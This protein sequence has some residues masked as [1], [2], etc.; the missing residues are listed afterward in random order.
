MFIYPEIYLYHSK[1]NLMNSLIRVLKDYRNYLEKHNLAKG[2]N[3]PY[4]VGWVDRF[5]RFAKPLQSHKF[6]TV[7]EMFRS[8]L[9]KTDIRPWQLRQAIDA[10]S[11]Y[12]Y[13]FR[14]SLPDYV[15]G[16][17]CKMSDKEICDL[18]EQFAA[19]KRYS[20]ATK[21]SYLH[22]IRRFLGWR[23]KMDIGGSFSEENVKGFLTHLVM[24]Q[25]VSAS[26]QNQAFNALLFLCR[27]C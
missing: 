12:K 18:A 26:T 15:D 10:V 1:G 24:V 7:L 13:Q 5:L 22:W 23:S 16:D 27:M 4:L 2:P 21:K 25:K 14:K 19:L 8:H 6:Q 11:I 20:F 3:I 9:E 17:A